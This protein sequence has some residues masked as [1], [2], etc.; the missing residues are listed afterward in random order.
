[1]QVGYRLLFFLG[2]F[3]W[4]PFMPYGRLGCLAKA[5]PVV[6]KINRL[7]SRYHGSQMADMPQAASGDRPTPYRT[8]E[9]HCNH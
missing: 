1:M 4:V 6:V 9:R 7:R 2:F 8:P 5:A 3:G